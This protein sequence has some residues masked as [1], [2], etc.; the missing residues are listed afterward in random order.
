MARN[1]GAPE[2]EAIILYL[3]FK[4]L[5]EEPP[6]L[7]RQSESELVLFGLKR[8]WINSLTNRFKTLEAGPIWGQTIS[9]GN[10]KGVGERRHRSMHT[11]FLKTQENPW[12]RGRG[13]SGSPGSRGAGPAAGGSLPAGAAPWF[14][15]QM[16]TDP[17]KPVPQA[18]CPSLPPASLPFFPK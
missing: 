4:I 8:N 18:P 11:R 1:Q 14:Q 6:P 3:N 9:A 17:R 15:R 16:G 2:R 12:G 5:T 10:R 13:A 7:P